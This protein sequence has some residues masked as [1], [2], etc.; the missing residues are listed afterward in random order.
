MAQK[1]AAPDASPSVIPFRRKPTVAAKPIT[2]ALPP[3]AVQEPTPPRPPAIDLTGQRK[4]WFLSGRGKTGKT[5]V[6]RYI[7]DRMADMGG[8]AVVAACDPVNRSLRRFLDN[9]AEPPSTDTEEVKDWL[10][11][12]LHSAMTDKFSA[13]IDLGGGN[14]SLTALVAQIP[15]LARM[16][17]DGGIEPVAVYMVGMDPDD[18]TPL[19]IAE[20]QGFRPRATAIVLNELAARN[21]QRFDQVLQDPT[22]RGAIERGAVQLWMPALWNVAAEACNTNAWRF[23]DAVAKGDA[24]VASSVSDWLKRM[25]AEFEPIRS[26]I[27]A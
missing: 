7:A 4:V 13:L 15:N 12:L 5:M 20:R 19:E 25:G 22:V 10:W 11:D 26:W 3:S 1:P 6:A 2:R 14:S 18:L 9:V 17:S 8:A 24:F 16:L 21:R 27:P 23:Q